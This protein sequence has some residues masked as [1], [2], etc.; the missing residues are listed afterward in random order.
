MELPVISSPRSTLGVEWEVLLLD[1]ETGQPRQCA[2]DILAALREKRLPKSEIDGHRIVGEMLRN[3]MELVTGICPTVTTA[4]EQLSSLLEQVYTVC[5]SLGVGITSVGT[6]PSAPWRTQHLS[7]HDRYQ[8]L[9]EHTGWWGRQMAIY[10]VHVHVGVEN[11]A[12]LVPLMNGLL[13]YGGQLLALSTSSPFWEGEDTGYA[14]QRTMLFQQLPT[15]GLPT[16]I[17]TWQE[18]TE[19][20]RGMQRAGAITELAELRWDIRPVPALGTLEVRICD[21]VPTLTEVRGIA[22]LIQCL[23]EYLSSH[24]DEGKELPRLERWQVEQ[25]KWRAARY[26]TKAQLILDR[27]GTLGCAED[28]LCDLVH[29]LY[30][31]AQ[32]LGCLDDLELIERI[33]AAGTPSARMR[34]AIGIDPAADNPDAT[35]PN[36]MSAVIEPLTLNEHASRHLTT[37]L[38]RAT[39]EN[40]LDI[41]P[42]Q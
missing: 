27:A 1:Q 18:Y 17:H 38:M 10:G 28:S 15:A 8:R 29:R 22:A 26:G 4:A 21:G 11:P 9:I 14:S 24:L 16:D 13:T 30:P 40:S 20:V 6:H 7:D 5:D 36:I 33:L 19:V 41:P 37:S 35:P 25:N 31:T 42:I 12:K 34:R 3:T 2:L 23:V 32:R 39:R